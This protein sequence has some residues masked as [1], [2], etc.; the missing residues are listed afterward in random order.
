MSESTE[1]KAMAIFVAAVVA[2]FAIIFGSLL[3]ASRDNKRADCVQ[4]GQPAA[5]CAELFK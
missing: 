2:F 4:Q 3:L 1:I 5:A